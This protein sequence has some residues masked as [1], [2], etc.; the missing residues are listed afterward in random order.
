MVDLF[1]VLCRV[2]LKWSECRNSEL[3]VF[4]AKSCGGLEEHITKC[5][6]VLC[7][8]HA[9]VVVVV[10]R[11]Y[12]LTLDSESSGLPST[13]NGLDC[14]YISRLQHPHS[15]LSVARD[16]VSQPTWLS[17]WNLAPSPTHTAATPRTQS[18]NSSENLRHSIDPEKDFTK[19]KSFNQCDQK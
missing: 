13:E 1:L 10:C 8:T 9:W 12:E 3:C 18:W 4:W 19:N 16:T 2:L 7:G 6:S 11:Y 15:L 17:L 14:E 5:M